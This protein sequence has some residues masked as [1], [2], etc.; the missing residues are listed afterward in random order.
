VNGLTDAFVVALRVARGLEDRGIR[1]TVGGSLASTIAGEPR[2]TVDVDF[3]VEIDET[4]VPLLVE[5]SS[6]SISSSRAVRPSTSISSTV[7]C[8]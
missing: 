2:S 4:K 3:V 8:P 6:K 5:E 1:Y 7:E